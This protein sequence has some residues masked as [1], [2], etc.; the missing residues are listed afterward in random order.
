MSKYINRVLK[1]Q[2]ENKNKFKWCI[3]FLLAHKNDLE[4][5]AE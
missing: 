4:I 3:Q 2:E 5:F 1:V